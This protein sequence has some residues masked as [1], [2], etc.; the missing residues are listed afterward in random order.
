MKMEEFLQL[1]QG[2]MT[3]ME[4]ETKFIEL[5]KYCTPMVADEK[6]KC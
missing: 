4:Y 1:K 2:S 3:M 5:S 6:K